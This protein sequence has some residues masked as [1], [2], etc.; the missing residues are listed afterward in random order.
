VNLWYKAAHTNIQIK[1]SDIQIKG[2]R[3]IKPTK[4]PKSKPLLYFGLLSYNCFI[5]QEAI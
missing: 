1:S 3:T 2:T 4:L 5:F